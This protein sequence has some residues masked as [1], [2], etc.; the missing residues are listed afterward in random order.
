MN[1][2]VLQNDDNGFKIDILEYSE[3]KD[4]LK[5]QNKKSNPFITKYEK[6]RLIGT[7][8]EQINKGAKLL[9]DIDEDD[10]ENYSN[11]IV[12]AEKEFMA[13]KIPLIVCRIFPDDTKEYWTLDELI[14]D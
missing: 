6:A 2:N 12:L 7:R 9:I 8:A 11:P 4:E 13:K 10:F 5:K 1:S 14:F 3:V